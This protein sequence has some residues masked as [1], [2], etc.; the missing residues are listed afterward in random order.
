MY[1]GPMIVFAAFTLLALILISIAKVIGWLLRRS[2][3]RTM[4]D[5]GTDTRALKGQ[6]EQSSS[7]SAA[8][9]WLRTSLG[10]TEEAQARKAEVAGVNAEIRR[11]YLWSAAAYA[12]VVSGAMFFLLRSTFPLAGKLMMASAALFPQ[13]L[14]LQSAIRLSVRQRFFGW[15][16]YVMANAIVLPL[17]TTPHYFWRNMATTMPFIA[18][19]PA[20]FLLILLQRRIQPFIVFLF[21]LIMS[22]VLLAAPFW[23]QVPEDNFLSVFEGRRG[24]VAVHN[25]MCCA[26]TLFTTLSVRAY[27]YTVACRSTS[28]APQPSRAF[29]DTMDAVVQLHANEPQLSGF[30]DYD[31]IARNAFANRDNDEI[32]TLVARLFDETE[33][34]PDKAKRRV[35]LAEVRSALAVRQPVEKYDRSYFDHLLLE[36]TDRVWTDPAFANRITEARRMV[37]Y[38]WRPSWDSYRCVVDE[39]PMPSITCRA[40]I[41][42]GIRERL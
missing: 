7:E 16:V 29:M 3:T 31:S 41:L 34:N 39:I 1:S 32:S 21:S 11:A 15:V 42:Y 40:L 24:R 10:L 12:S 19:L 6:A 14:I 37:Q 2:V 4:G 23:N 8:R 5:S 13:L 30:S 22:L 33:N 17:I 35:G 18:F 27:R 9:A 25:S 20:P 26:R 38:P 36:T 28:G